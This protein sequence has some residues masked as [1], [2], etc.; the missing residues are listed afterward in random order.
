MGMHNLT[1]P[2][3]KFLCGGNCTVTTIYHML[4]Y[5]PEIVAFEHWHNPMSRDY[6]EVQYTERKEE[7]THR[8]KVNSK[9]LTQCPICMYMYIYASK[10]CTYILY[11][12]G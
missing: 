4:T 1:S 11:T 5:L 6:R 8:M 7:S 10:T 3:D 2:F 12:S 9:M